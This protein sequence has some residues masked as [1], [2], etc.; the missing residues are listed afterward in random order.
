MA[1]LLQGSA[2][3]GTLGEATINLASYI[4]PE[5]STASLPLRQHCSHGTIL[6][7]R[8][9]FSNTSLFKIPIFFI[10]ISVLSLHLGL[11]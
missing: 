11:N 6:Q 1:S 2:R 8:I 9:M 10:L 3:F 4:R 5:T 7:V